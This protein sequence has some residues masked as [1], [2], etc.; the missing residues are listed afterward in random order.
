VDVIAGMQYF[1]TLVKKF[2]VPGTPSVVVLDSRTG[3][4]KTLYG[5]S[6]ITSDNILKAVAE[7]SGK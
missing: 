1:S 4:T 2:K 7:V 6:E 3:K 5:M